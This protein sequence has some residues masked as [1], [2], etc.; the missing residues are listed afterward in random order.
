MSKC[1]TLNFD[2]KLSLVFL[3]NVATACFRSYSFMSSSSDELSQL[4]VLVMNVIVT[5]AVSQILQRRRHSLSCQVLNTC[6]QVKYLGH[7]I[8]DALTDDEDIFRQCCSRCVEAHGQSGGSAQCS[9]EEKMTW[10]KTY[11]TALDTARL[12]SKHNKASRGCKKQFD[13]SLRILLTRARL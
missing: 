1:E 4:C 6:R 13:D 3:S 11:C 5:F 12:C 8:P 7:V 9:D 10:L 2:I